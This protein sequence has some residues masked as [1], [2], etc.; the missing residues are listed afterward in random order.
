MLYSLLLALVL[1]DV[2]A[3]QAEQAAPA[4]TAPSIT[5][6]AYGERLKLRGLPNGGRINAS[7]YRGAQPHAEGMEQ[8]RSLGITTI[9]DLRGEDRGKSAWERQRAE[10]LG[11][12]FLSIPVSGWAAPSDAQVA[13]FLSLFRNNPKEKVFVHCRLGEDRTGVFVAA[14]R[15]AFDGWPA[16]QAINEMYYFGFNGL[17][18]ASMK[19]FIKAF[20]SQLK[21]ESIFAD[22]RQRGQEPVTK[23]DNS[24]G[25]AVCAN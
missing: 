12:H 3:G 7:L 4:S 20:P 11:I 6:T 23:C 22:Y 8:L 17:W 15:M 18:H 25:A 5:R 2:P 9:V 24:S 1:T 21:T 10:A 16:Q 14:Y 19:S 13:Q